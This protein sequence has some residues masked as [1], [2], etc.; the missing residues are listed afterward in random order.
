MH[1]E[2]VTL[3]RPAQQGVYSE[4]LTVVYIGIGIGIGV[5]IAIAIEFNPG[6][7]INCR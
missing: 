3:A 1:L 7:L 6:M 2:L 5:A 4:R